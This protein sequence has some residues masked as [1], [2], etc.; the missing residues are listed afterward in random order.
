MTNY[1]RNDYELNSVI[2]EELNNI[3]KR[4]DKFFNL[5]HIRDNLIKVIELSEREILC[6]EEV[7]ELEESLYFI[8]NNLKNKDSLRMMNKIVN[9]LIQVYD[10]IRYNNEFNDNV[11][12]I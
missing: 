3:M 11:V 4:H 7:T 5:K 8:S 2:S 12:N 10:D 9:E 6:D 1:E